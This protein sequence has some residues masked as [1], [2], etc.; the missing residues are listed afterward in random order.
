MVQEEEALRGS[1]LVAV[2]PNYRLSPQTQP[3][4][5]RLPLKDQRGQAHMGPFPALIPI[6]PKGLRELGVKARVMGF[7]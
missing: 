7:Q 2:Y 6:G 4:Q 3:R 1:H 5:A